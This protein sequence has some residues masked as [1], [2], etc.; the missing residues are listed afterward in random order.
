MINHI[1][2]E[3]HGL[4]CNRKINIACTKPSS[5]QNTNRI[6]DKC[7]TNMSNHFLRYILL[8]LI[9]IDEFASIGLSNRIHGKVAP[10]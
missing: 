9:R 5:S 8:P 3:R 1:L 4:I 6:F 2:H 7:I 10:G